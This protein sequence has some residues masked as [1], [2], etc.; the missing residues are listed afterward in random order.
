MSDNVCNEAYNNAP[1]AAVLCAR[2]YNVNVCSVSNLK[3][4]VIAFG[5]VI[6]H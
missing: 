6:S 2:G 1:T 3:F 4:L 5:L